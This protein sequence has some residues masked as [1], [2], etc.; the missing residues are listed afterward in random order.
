MVATLPGRTHGL[1]LVAEPLIADLG[2][3]RTGFA[4]LNFWATLI[5]AAFC[6][7]F[8]WCLDRFGV[9]AL[10]APVLGGLALSVWVIGELAPGQPNQLF[11]LLTL[12]RGLGQSAL[13]VLSLALIGKAAAGRSPVIMGAYSFLLAAGFM[14]AFGLIGA[15]D[16]HYDWRAIWQGVGLAVGLAAPVVW[17]ALGLLPPVE[18]PGEA[19]DESAGSTLAEAAGTPAFWLFGLAVSLFGLIASGTSLFQQSILAERGFDRETFLTLATLAPVVGLA[20]NL[21]TGYL[22]TFVPMG[23]PD[24]RRDGPH[25]RGAAGVPVRLVPDARLP[26]RGRDGR[27]GRGGDGD[28]LRLLGAGCSAGGT[29]GGSRARRR[30][31]PCSP[32]PPARSP[33]LGPRR[34]PAR[35]SPPSRRSPGRPSRSPPGPPRARPALWPPPPERSADDGD[36]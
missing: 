1:G 19:D 16:R 13:S 20:S 22:M 26:V 23:P 29:W 34:R 24:G 21:A 15:L 33:W 2:L 11:V 28:L 32:R 5:G 8:G 17:L 14:A 9:R 4:D 30:R 25:G 27:L 3:S 18:A 35:T 6:V 36:A 7:P 31:S 12:T 10:L